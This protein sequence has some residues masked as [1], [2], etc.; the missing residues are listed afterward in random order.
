[1]RTDEV[2]SLALRCLCSA[3]RSR[4]DSAPSRRSG[5]RARRAWLLGGRAALCT[6]GPVPSGV[7]RVDI[8]HSL[9][10]GVR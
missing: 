2:I 8:A 1:M 6:R 7:F 4:Q 9:P 3:L 10:V 5:P